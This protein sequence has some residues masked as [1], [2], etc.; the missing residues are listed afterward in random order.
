MIVYSDEEEAFKRVRMVKQYTG[1]WPGV[2]RLANG[3]FRL[4]YDLVLP[5]N[6]VIR[7]RVPR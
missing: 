1:R 6:P 5:T 7:N 3:L 2:V 4:T